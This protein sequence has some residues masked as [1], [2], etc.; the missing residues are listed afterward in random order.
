MI[1]KITK[2]TDPVWKKKF[3]DVAT[4]PQL[5]KIVADMSE[6]LAFTMGVGLAAPQ[7]GYP[8]RLFIISYGDLKETFL[9]P[10]LISKGQ[11]TDWVEE[12]CLSI[13]GHRGL[14][15][16][17]TEV[18]I[19]YTNLAGVR[20][21]G[22][23]SGFYARIFQHEYD[24]LNS[25]FYV[26]RIQKPKHLYKFAPIRIVF[27]GSNDFSATILLSLIG[28]TFVG[29]YTI[30]L[31]VTSPDR[32]AGR[33]Q[34]LQV[35]P[36]KKLTQQFNIETIAPE[37]LARRRGETFELTNTDVFEQIKKSKPDV[38]VL[39]SYGKILPKEILTLPKYAPINVHPSLLPK[40]RGPSPIQAPILNGDKTTGVTIMQMNEKMDEG[41]LYI[42]GRY[43]LKPN[44]TADSLSKTLAELAKDLLHHTIHYLII[45]KIKTRPQDPTKASYTKII[46]R[47]D[48][49]IDWK[50][51]P[52]N[53]DRMVRAYFPWPGVW[54]EYNG[55]I[56]KLLPEK[57]VQLE[58]KNPVKLKV[59]K[60]GY[61]DFDLDW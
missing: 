17:S 61:K 28:Q 7:V 4:T 39:A 6:T 51:P 49:R 32:P 40:Y 45:K 47:E 16:R 50:K 30:P 53:L 22:K 8:Y 12:G 55:K 34:Q 46:K 36:V 21:R 33:G 10:K 43:E 48:G 59:F 60:Q 11:E 54:T 26:Q 9:D 20:K 38:L 29:D 25:T 15:E 2:S 58:G 13:P 5:E 37:K 23:L 56:L 18:E 41:E 35:S 42:K 24:H 52:K 57:M 1:L 44:E 31:V 3:V 27:F 19:E 14:V